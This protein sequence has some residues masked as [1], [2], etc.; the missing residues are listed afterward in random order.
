MANKIE[1]TKEKSNNQATRTAQKANLEAMKEELSDLEKQQPQEQDQQ[2]SK[3]KSGIGNTV[4]KLP[5]TLQRGLFAVSLLIINPVAFIIAAVLYAVYKT[6]EAR[7]K[8]TT[9]QS[10]R[11]FSDIKKDTLKELKVKIKGLQKDLRER[12]KTSKNKKKD[13]VK[14]KVTGAKPTKTPE[15]LTKSSLAGMMTPLNES[16]RPFLAK[17][18]AR[19][20]KTKKKSKTKKRGGGLRI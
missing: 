20:A 9:K 19:L 15:K 5:K 7:G 17:L 2:E 1:S 4:Q 12:E 13:K 18:R 8:Q 3:P 10:K 14:G 16:K 11:S 6:L